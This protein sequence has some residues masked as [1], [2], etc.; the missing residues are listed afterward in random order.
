MCS[1]LGY[2]KLITTPHIYKDL[3]PNT[4]NNIET[5]YTSLL[6]LQKTTAL[7]SLALLLNI[8][9]MNFL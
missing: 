7:R 1:Q 2:K 5:A 3:Y 6:K 4:I 9:W 8:W